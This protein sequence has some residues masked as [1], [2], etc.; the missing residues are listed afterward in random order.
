MSI[1]TNNQQNISY[2]KDGITSCNLAPCNK[3]AGDIA[4]KQY[5]DMR[6]NKYPLP[7]LMTRITNWFFG[8]CCCPSATD[9]WFEQ[10]NYPKNNKDRNCCHDPHTSL[11]D[12]ATEISFDLKPPS[13]LCIVA[14][15]N[16][17]TPFYSDNDKNTLSRE[18]I[19]GKACVPQPFSASCDKDT[20][21]TLVTPMSSSA[22]ILTMSASS[23][24]SLESN[25]PALVIESDI[26]SEAISYH[27][28]GEKQS[29]NKTKRF[30]LI[31]SVTFPA[32]WVVTKDYDAYTYKNTPLK[33]NAD[34]INTVGERSA[35]LQLEEARHSQKTMNFRNIPESGYSDA[36]YSQNF[37]SE[38]LAQRRLK[39]LNVSAAAQQRPTKESS[40]LQPSLDPKELESAVI[41][42]RRKDETAYTSANQIK[43]SSATARYVD[44]LTPVEE[45]VQERAKQRLIYA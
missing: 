1:K 38:Q 34:C 15:S 30:G 28:K 5:A 36:A 43:A 32:G 16:S 33:H 2:Y 19:I 18:N 13:T 45:I 27:D 9:T 8:S 17:S 6:N 37:S 42:R 40:A 20:S 39:A 29:N 44:K 35:R 22:S 14:D 26:E 3:R 10:R 24:A 11:D 4:E 31:S 25:Q 41:K 23:F 7:P 21:V 12:Y